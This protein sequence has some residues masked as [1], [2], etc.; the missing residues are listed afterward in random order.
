MKSNVAASRAAELDKP[1]PLGKLEL[2]IALNGFTLP[3]KDEETFF[4][5]SYYLY[6]I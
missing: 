3:I 4:S 2:I 5:N 1:D 6:I